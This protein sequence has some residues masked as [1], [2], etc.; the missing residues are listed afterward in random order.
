MTSG[1][2]KG[3]SSNYLNVWKSMKSDKKTISPYYTE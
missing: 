2:N 1:K 3:L